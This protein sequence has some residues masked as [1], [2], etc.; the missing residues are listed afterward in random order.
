MT[1][2]VPAPVTDCDLLAANPPDP[3]RIVAGVPRAAVDLP[4]AI[5]ACRAAVAQYPDEGRLAYQL[6]RCLFYAG[7]TPA[8]LDSFRRAAALGYRQ[9]H[10]ILGLIALRRYPGVPFDPA[11]IE[12]HWRAA[13][14]ADHLNAQVSYAREWL[15]GAFADLAQRAPADE[16]KNFL[17]RARP[18]VDYLG[19]LLV[20]D[21]LAAL[22]AASARRET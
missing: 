1:T 5:A 6:G 11:A 21:L 16:V 10:F 14:R 3:D 19:G 22:A 2:A 17:E 8:A 13:A 7:D 12:Q 4:R 18:R 9:A 20:D 15:K